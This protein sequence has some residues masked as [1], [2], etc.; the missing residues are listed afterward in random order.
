MVSASTIN[1]S[2]DLGKFGQA[3]T[4]VQNPDPKLVNH[5][6]FCFGS[7][8]TISK[9]EDAR[10]A[11]DVSSLFI[12]MKEDSEL[13]LISISLR[14]SFNVAVKVLIKRPSQL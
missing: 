9:P 2:C 1:L 13:H 11:Y 5:E 12:G 14:S 6:Y 7:Q 4:F 8:L 3:L 10:K